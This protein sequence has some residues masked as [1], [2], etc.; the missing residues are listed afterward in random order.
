MS[1][2]KKERKFLEKS[3]TEKWEIITILLFFHF[4]KNVFSFLRKEGNNHEYLRF[5]L[6]IDFFSLINSYSIKVCLFY[7]TCSI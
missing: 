4:Q 6:R 3:L 2:K 5:N 7:Y 1:L